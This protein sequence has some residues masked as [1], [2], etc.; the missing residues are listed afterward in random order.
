MSRV[1]TRVMEAG[2]AGAVLRIYQD[3]LDTGNASFETTAPPWSNWDSAHLVRHRYVATI[4][5]DVVGWV[6][7]AMTSARPVYAGVLQESVY[8]S[9]IA[10]GRGVG[11]A[12][13]Q[14]LVESTEASGVWT[15][16]AGIF[17]ENTASFAL[18]TS[19][20]YRIVGRRE[21]VG[22]MNGWWRDVVLVER[23]SDRVGT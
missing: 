6:A 2:D 20:G 8:V 1:E 7:T 3:G 11:R 16:Q 4:D 19:A 18:H 22:C 17:P 5:G 9:A 13:L 23:R 10:R 14:R 12:L 21:R 15:L